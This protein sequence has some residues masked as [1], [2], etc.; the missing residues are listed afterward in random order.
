MV[1]E[2]LLNIW[3]TKV[4]QYLIIGLKIVAQIL[5]KPLSAI[6]CVFVVVYVNLEITNYIYL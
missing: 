3:A 2:H 5:P 1:F 4:A 6:L